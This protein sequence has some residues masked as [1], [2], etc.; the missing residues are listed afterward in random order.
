MRVRG[1]GGEKGGGRGQNDFAPFPRLTRQPP[2]ST[3][4]RSAA[5]NSLP[6][7]GRPL[8]VGLGCDGLWYGSFIGRSPPPP[9]FPLLMPDSMIVRERQSAN[10]GGG[11]LLDLNTDTT[12]R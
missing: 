3:D 5:R 8:A 9:P 1:K 12:R 6:L 11:H 10:R 4:P 7:S 2:D